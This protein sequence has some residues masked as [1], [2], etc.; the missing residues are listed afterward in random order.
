MLL[1]AVELGSAAGIR[2]G[3]RHNL[4]L[5]VPL[6]ICTL[7]MSLSSQ[8]CQSWVVVNVCRML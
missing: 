3:L 1:E 7:K 6:F 5:S 2:V 4:V 8:G